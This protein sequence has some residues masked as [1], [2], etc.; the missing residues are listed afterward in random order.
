MTDHKCGVCGS[1]D[2]E[3]RPY[4][5]NHS[6]I[7]FDCAFSTQASKAETERNYLMQLNA[8]GPCAVIGTEVGPFPLEALKETK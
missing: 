6:M 8:A 3:L 4:G 2:E 5:K 7:C 1:V